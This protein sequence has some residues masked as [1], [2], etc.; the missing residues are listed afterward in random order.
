MTKANLNNT[1][2]YLF[3]LL[4]LA[5]CS[6]DPNNTNNTIAGTIKYKVNGNQVTM[7]GY[8]ISN[9]EYVTFYKQLQGSLITH[10][11]YLLNAQK[12]ANNFLAFAIKSDSLGVRNYLMDSLYFDQTGNII[13]VN[14]NGQQSS[15]DYN[16]DN[17]SVNITSYANGMISGTFSGKLTPD[18]Y[19]YSARGSTVITEGQFQNIKCIY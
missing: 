5:A 2:R 14:Y 11:R 15:V 17:L 9:A 1:M 12:G 13:M 7:T 16:G 18:P 10:T 8:D 19:N 4:T 6:P 3:I